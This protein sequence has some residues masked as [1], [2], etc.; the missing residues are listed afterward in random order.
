MCLIIASRDGTLPSDELLR[1]AQAD[2]HHG[3]GIMWAER[4]KVRAVKG[5]KLS[6]LMRN[7]KALEGTPFVLHFRWATHGNID[8][9]NCHPFKITDDL[10]MAH[11]GI[12]HVEMPREDRS[13]S[14]HFAQELAVILQKYPWLKDAEMQS[15]L[16][17]YTE[18]VCG[19]SSKIAFLRGNGEIFIA[20]EKLGTEY[21]GLWLSNNYSL[22]GHKAWFE[23]YNVPTIADAPAAKSSGF[24]GDGDQV[25]V[26][27]A[28]DCDFCGDPS[29]SLRQFEGQL[30]CKDCYQWAQA[31]VA[32]YDQ[33]KHFEVPASEFA[34]FSDV[35][36]AV[37]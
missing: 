13:D 9:A 21:E 14:W 27:Q 29:F 1:I 16:L 25:D 28:V 5:F 20:N 8:I 32:M 12:L 24:L 26:Q 19:S 34:E 3:W 18:W 35:P 15:R 36:F 33:V 31:E 2:N 4:G 37:V 10:W 17:Q 7:V 11:N 6:S 22:P 23:Y 30:F